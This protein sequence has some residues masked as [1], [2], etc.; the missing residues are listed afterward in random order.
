M[1]K[2]RNTRLQL[3]VLELA[4]EFLRLRD[5]ADGLVEVVLGDRV[6]V[7]LDCEKTTVAPLEAVTQSERRRNDIRFRDHVP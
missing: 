1:Q 2:K 7:V 5:L 6:S 4:L 3:L